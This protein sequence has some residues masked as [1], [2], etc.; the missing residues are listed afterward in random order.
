MPPS[1]GEQL[2]VTILVDADHAH[3]RSLTGLIIFIGSTQKDK[4][5]LQQA[6]I[7]QNSLL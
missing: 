3:D 7:M 5:Q 4:E 2:Q 1:F 6:L